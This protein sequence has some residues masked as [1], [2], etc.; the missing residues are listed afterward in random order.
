MNVRHFFNSVS[1]NLF[2]NV[3]K[4]VLGR[5][6]ALKSK[7]AESEYNKKDK[8]SVIAF[9]S[10][11]LSQSGNEGE[12]ISK[13]IFRAARKTNFNSSNLQEVIINNY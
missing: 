12:L 2:I 9:N 3:G 7:H 1:F 11:D 4:N 13:Y 10:I 6:S 8:L 5:A